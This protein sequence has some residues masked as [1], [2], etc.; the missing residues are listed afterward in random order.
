[1]IKIPYYDKII[2][3]I[4]LIDFE[5]T[6]FENSR[7]KTLLCAHRGLSSAN[8]PCNTLSAFKAALMAGADM[9]EL[10]VSKSIDGKYFVFH[11]GMEHAHINKKKL[12]AVM[13]SDKVQKLRFVNQDDSATDYPI[14]TLEEI[15][16]FLKD[17]CYINV[18]KFWTDVQGITQCI[19]R[20]GVEKQVVVKTGTDKKYIDEVLKYAPDLMFMP[21]VRHRDDITDSLIEKGI[22]CIGAEVLFD[23]ENDPVASEQYINEMHKKGRI[24]FANAIVYNKSD[25]LSAGHSDDNSIA[26]SPDFGWGWLADKGFDIIQT[27]WCSLVKKYLENRKAENQK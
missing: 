11:P 2:K 6:I 3:V 19:R 13:K 21:I 23:N 24:V 20:C 4:E 7:N 17:K 14:N 18:D 15:L 25:I 12:I 1:M 10:D 16:D 5:K 8:I 27:D 22:N 26:I 9:V